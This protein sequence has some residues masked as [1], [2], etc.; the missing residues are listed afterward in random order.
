MPSRT[1]EAIV[2]AGGLGT[3]LRSVV[4]GLP[5]P[6]APVHGRPF[7]AYVLDALSRQSIR[8]VVLATGYRGDQVETAIGRAW[9]GMGVAYSHETEPLG[10]GGAI[11]RAIR[12]IEGSRFFVL[13]GDTF[14]KLD[15]AAF[16]RASEEQR[17]RLGI[18]LARVDDIARYGAVELRDR[19]V[20]GFV[21]KGQTGSG[22]INAGVYWVDKGLLDAMPNAYRFSFEGDV[23]IP[24]SQ[25]EP[26][27][28]FTQ[29][30]RFIDIGVPED[31][32][33]A[34]AFFA[35]D[36]EAAS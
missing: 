32:A 30:S 7:L 33:R 23:L 12:H 9:K 11:K 17:V 22:Y 28:A 10:T 24:L 14:V 15:Y 31:Y 18:A 26:V 2:L 13:N 4:A 21:E 19:C 36:R 8:R 3:R 27:A 20:H 5:K 1:D 34:S 6:L 16:D 29:T 35:V 25:S